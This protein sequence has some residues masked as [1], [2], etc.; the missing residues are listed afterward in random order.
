M[1]QSNSGL[2][3]YHIEWKCSDLQSCILT[4]NMWS[5]PKKQK[6]TGDQL[7]RHKIGE[8]IQMNRLINIDLKAPYKCEHGLSSNPPVTPWQLLRDTAA[9]HT[10]S[11]FGDIFID[12]GSDRGLNGPLV[13]ITEEDGGEN[14][15]TNVGKVRLELRYCSLDVL[16]GVEMCKNLKGV[17]LLNRV[18]SDT[19][20]GRHALLQ[21]VLLLRFCLSHTHRPVFKQCMVT[22]WWPRQ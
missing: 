12:P 17:E 11:T 13:F 19:L 15:C 9:E 16:G 10:L 21:L 18:S 6:H 7:H 4:A 1:K 2:L 20:V 8:A 14:I 3:H 22:L 5:R